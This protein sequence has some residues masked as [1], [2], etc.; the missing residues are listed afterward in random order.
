MTLDPVTIAVAVLPAV[1]LMI[2]IYRADRLEKESPKLLKSLFVGGIFSIPLAIALES[3]GENYLLPALFSSKSLA[4]IIVDN[5]IVVALVE[6]FSK[7]LFM[8]QR[9]WKNPEFNCQFDA[10]VYCVFASLVFA[11]LENI[12][13]V[14]MMGFEVGIMRAFTAVPGHACFGAIMG[15]YY[16]RAKRYEMEGKTGKAATLRN[17]AVIT[18]AIWH[19][20]Y[21]ALATMGLTLPFYGLIIIMYIYAISLVRKAAKTDSYFVAPGS[22]AGDIAYYLFNNRD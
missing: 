6:E 7:Y 2:F 11:L 14:G 5:F 19:G 8:K 13:Y 22:D 18:P 15:I 20:A 9:T 4:Y 3:V 12:G 1:I 21:D 17:S 10:V 16:G